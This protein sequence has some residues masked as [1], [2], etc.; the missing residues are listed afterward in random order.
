MS[1]TQDACSG[2]SIALDSPEFVADPF[3]TYERLRRDS[4]VLRTRT[5]YMGDQ[6]I[7]LLSRYQDCVDLTTDQRFRRVVEGSD[8]LPIPRAL[9][10]IA[11]DGMI[12][13]DDPEHMRLRKLVSRAFTPRS[14]ARLTDR[15]EEITNELL[16][17]F[18]RGQHIDVLEDYAL[19]IP[20]TVI[21][22][23]VGVPEA[24]RGRFHDGMNLVMN[25]MAEFGLDQMAAK[26]E[27]VIDFVRELI[28][29]RRSEP[30]EDIMTGLIHASED[31]DT[32]SEDEVVAMVFTLVVAGYETTY[33]LIANGVAALLTH[34]DQLQLLKNDPDLIS[35]A[36]EEIL[37]YTGTIGGTKPNYASEDVELHGVTI[38]RGAIV[39][40]LLASA[41]RDPDEFENPDLFDITRTPNHHIAFSKGSHFCL[42]ANLARMETRVAISNLITRFPELHLA[43]DPSELQFHPVP[44]W[45]R[46]AS[47]PVTLE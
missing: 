11:T 12:M 30:A 2:E 46:L 4:P 3:P 17:G 32:L 41:N 29:R 26:M 22:E 21:S 18:R 16:D 35:S 43:V 24:D 36:V 28:D 44:F 6:D 13:M 33:N 19:P 31:G 8:P 25:G 9:K 23:M 15:T 40:P 39:I 1:A 42:G 7:Y 47:L 37:R 20:V 27:P 14:I 45:R 10:F 38:P 34:P 5:A